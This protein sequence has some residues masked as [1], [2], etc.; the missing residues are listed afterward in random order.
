MIAITLRVPPAEQDEVTAELW[1]AG[2]AGITENGEWLTAFFADESAAE[3]LVE[4]FRDWHPESHHE[5][6][7]DWEAESRE[8]WQ[9]FAVGER[10]WLVPEWR[11]DPPPQGRARL[12]IHPGM[13]CGTG[14]A[15]ATPLCLCAMEK[16]M[17]PG[18]SVLDVGTG[19]GIL[20]DA[21]TVLGAATVVACDIDQEA[22]AI[23]KR[24]VA[25][26]AVFTGSARSVRGGRFDVVVANL[27]AA[28]LGG[29]GPDLMRARAHD[30]VVILSGFRASEAARVAAAVKADARET[31]TDSDWACLVL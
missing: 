28:S 3:T 11:D 29:I 21:A 19:S 23:A 27:N 20:A 24:N 12:S 6:D 30:G 14:A 9:P 15:P 22:A 17:R 10:F 26:L 31:L 25:G 16:W 1:D 2:T 5:D 4:Q 18:A 8:A 7:R 13:A